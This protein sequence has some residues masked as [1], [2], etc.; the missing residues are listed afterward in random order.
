M[1]TTQPTSTNATAHAVAG[2]DA[3]SAE[4]WVARLDS[5]ECTA[6]DR[7][8]F[9]RWLDACPDNVTAYVEAERV[10]QAAAQLAGDEMLQA[11]AR[12][13][14]RQSGR[15]SARSRWWVPTTM[16]ASLL[17][18]TVVGVGWLR[19]PA[20]VDSVRYVTQVGEQRS[21]RLADGTQVML[22]TDSVILA[23]FGDER[24]EVEVDRGRVQFQVAADPARPFSVKAGTGTIRDIGT[25]FQ[26]S[27]NGSEVNVGLIEG[28]V[29]ISNGLAQ[30]GSALRPGQQ[31][32]Y[33]HSGRMT[34]PEPL[35]LSVAQSW[36]GGDLVFKNRRLDALLAE[37]NRYSATKLRLADPNLGKITVSGVFHIGD[38][39]ALLEALE[40]GWS[41]KAEHAADDEIVL[42]RNPG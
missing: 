36:P 37:M 5:P 1:N 9:E 35:D 28:A 18:A 13:A 23:R 32:S 33:D 26:V 22:D 15:E 42:H 10:H 30:A 3:G 8:E 27:K 7:A 39:A 14:W 19:S 40:Q 11:A 4:A 41:L 6:R 24:R 29:V 21:L 38:Q 12:I 34:P 16:V 31:L 2:A 25:T 17:V 20:P